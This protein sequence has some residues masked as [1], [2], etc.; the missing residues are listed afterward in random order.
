MGK[1]DTGPTDTPEVTVLVLLI[2][3]IFD[4]NQVTPSNTRVQEN[5]GDTGGYEVSVTV[6]QG[7]PPRLPKALP[8]FPHL[9]P[10]LTSEFP[11]L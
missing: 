7:D 8:V 5:A 9:R 3:P 4:R 10:D 1:F 6:A 11:L 2:A